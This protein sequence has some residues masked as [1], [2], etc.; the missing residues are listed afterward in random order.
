[1]DEKGMQRGGKGQI[2]RNKYLV[3]HAQQTNYKLH[4][5]DLQLITIIECVCADG[6]AIQPTFIFAGKDFTY[7]MFEGVDP[8]VCVVMKSEP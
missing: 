3:P 4:S 1:M 2:K 8:N 7:N 6:S 5:S